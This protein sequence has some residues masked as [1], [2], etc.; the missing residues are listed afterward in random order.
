MASPAGNRVNA[1]ILAFTVV[2][3]AVVFFRLFTRIAVI[4]NAGFEDVCITLAMVFSIALTVAISEQ[5]RNGL[6]MHI[7]ELGPKMM[8]D[9]QKAFWASVWVY[10]LALS[11]TKISILV[12]YLRIFPTPRFRAVCCVVLSFVVGF[13]IWNFFGSIFLCTPVQ[14]FW[15]KSLKK[16]TCLNQFVVWFVNAGVNIAQDVIILILPMPLLHRLNVP[17]AQKRALIII[18]SLGGFVC[19]VSIIRLSSLVRISNSKDPTFDNPPAATFSAVEV[20]VGI[21]CA[22]L[23]SI[24]PALSAILPRHFPPTSRTTNVQAPDEERAKHARTVSASTRP[25]TAITRPY[26]AQSSRPSL[27]RAGN[28]ST[29]SRAGSELKEMYR[30]EARLYG[31]GSKVNGPVRQVTISSASRLPPYSLAPPRLPMLPEDMA[32]ISPIEQPKQQVPFSQKFG[33]RPNGRIPLY[34]KPL[35]LTPFPITD[36]PWF[37]SQSD[38]G[39]HSGSRRSRQFA[40]S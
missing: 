11:F 28:N 9:S 13:G 22:C 40:R 8:I 19:L 38:V 39:D 1:V 12:Q 18:F 20:N 16:G 3:G 7:T 29:D 32:L 26:T 17:R 10:Y 35:P 37:W 27:S 14:F 30:E 25:L 34:Q 31:T 6:G 2:S 24:R 36:Q 33:R 23:P 4:K 15:N 5:V 21:I